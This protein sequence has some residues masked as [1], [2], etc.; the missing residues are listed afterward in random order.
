[1]NQRQEQE[2]KYFKDDIIRFI[3]N[4]EFKQLLKRL[5]KIGIFKELQTV[6]RDYRNSSNYLQKTDTKWHPELHDAI[7]HRLDTELMKLIQKVN[8]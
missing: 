3:Q 1:M 6:I 2:L 7:G 8:R 5:S 4:A